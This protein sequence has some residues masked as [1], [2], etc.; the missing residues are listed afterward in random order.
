MA[1]G[2]STG[3]VD[4]TFTVEP[5][6]AGWR[7]DR[8]LCEKIRRLSRQRVQ[9]IIENDLICARKLKPSTLV[10]PGLTFTLRRKASLEPEVPAPDALKVLHRDDALL[11]LDKPAGL[12]IHP[13]ARYHA[14]TLVSQLKARGE[15]AYPAHRLD[16]ETSG[17][18]VCARTVEASRTLMHAFIGGE[19]HKEYLAI[20]E[21]QPPDDS[22]HVEAPIAEGTELIRIAVRID[23]QVGKPARTD[24]QVERRFERGG[25]RFALLRCFPRTGR[26]HQIRIHLH[27]AGFPLVGDKMYGPDPGYFDRFSKHALEPEGWARLRLPRHALHA[28]RLSLAHPVSRAPLAFESPL[29]ADLDAFLDGP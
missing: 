11:V 25:E 3:F 19:V 20:C 29:P 16:R 6:Y 22:F 10:T 13:T 1:P 5:N 9:R 28:A 23:H 15:D 12:P 4:L 17:L 27:H 26:Q 8:Y 18:L 24:F 21:G 2:E 14:G 7:L